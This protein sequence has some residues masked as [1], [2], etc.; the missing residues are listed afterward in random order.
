MRSEAEELSSWEFIVHF[1]TTLRPYFWPDGVCSKLLAFSCFVAL[2]ASKV[3][4]LVGPIFL[5][6]AVDRLGDRV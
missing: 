1:M 3:C 6:L 2:G 4:N 5:S